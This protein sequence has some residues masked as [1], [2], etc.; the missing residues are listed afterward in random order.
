[1]LQNKGFLIIELIISVFLICM[2]ITVVSS[3]YRQ[4]LAYVEKQKKYELLYE[5]ALSL[6][7]KAEYELKESS[8]RI[9]GFDYSI[10]I[11]K[12]REEKKEGF[13]ILLYK[14]NLN[15]GG[16]RFSFYKTT[17]EKTKK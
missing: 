2:V 9:N 11:D 4:Y 12:V 8:G 17:Y 1:M 15:V 16:K 13:D 7:D 14:I 3:A 10:K 6:K 5:T